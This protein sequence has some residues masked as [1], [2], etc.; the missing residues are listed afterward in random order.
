MRARVS[1]TGLATFTGL[2]I[3]ALGTKQLTAS[4]PGLTSGVSAQLHHH[5]HCATARVFRQ[6]QYW[7]YDYSLWVGNFRGAS[8]ARDAVAVN[9]DDMMLTLRMSKDD[10]TFDT[11]ATSVCRRIRSPH[12]PPI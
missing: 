6:C 4:A 11:A 3:N 12:A 5:R 8:T 10:G 2:Q 9:H 1:E 7:P